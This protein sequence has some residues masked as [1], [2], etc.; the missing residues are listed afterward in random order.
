MILDRTEGDGRGNEEDRVDRERQS[1]RP[2]R[3]GAPGRL[4]RDLTIE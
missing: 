4:D 2:G 3:H 1:R